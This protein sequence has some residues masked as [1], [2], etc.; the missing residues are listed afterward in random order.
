MFLSTPEI[1]AVILLIIPPAI[2]VALF[3]VL[4]G[5]GVYVVSVGVVVFATLST[6]ASGGLAAM[7]GP[8]CIMVIIFG[9]IAALLPREVAL[10]MWGV[11]LAV[12]FGL[13]LLANDG[14]PK[15]PLQG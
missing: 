15:A 7:I 1:I 5:I 12:I 14:D 8:F 3:G 11:L 9:G 10:G 13:T 2:F 6:Q 4:L